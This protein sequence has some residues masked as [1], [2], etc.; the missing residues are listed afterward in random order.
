LNGD[1]AFG[2]LAAAEGIRNGSFSLFIT[3]ARKKSVKK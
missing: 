2:Q 1:R 3:E